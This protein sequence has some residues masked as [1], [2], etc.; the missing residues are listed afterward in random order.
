[1]VYPNFYKYHLSLFRL[2]IIDWIVKENIL[3]RVACETSHA[4]GCLPLNSTDRVTKRNG[5]KTHLLQW[6]TNKPK[7]NS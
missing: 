5:W 7:V 4:D 1:M 6:K 2:Q 3:G